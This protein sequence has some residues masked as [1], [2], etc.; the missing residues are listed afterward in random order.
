[1]AGRGAADGQAELIL[2]DQCITLAPGDSWL[3]PAHAEHAYRVIEPF[4]AVEATAPPAQM[5]GRDEKG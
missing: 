5:H 4:T 1:V 2:E 3:V